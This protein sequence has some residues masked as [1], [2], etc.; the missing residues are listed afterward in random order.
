MWLECQFMDTEVDGSNPV[1]SMSCS[2]A[3]QFIRVASVDSALK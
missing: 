2:S 3:K 1:I